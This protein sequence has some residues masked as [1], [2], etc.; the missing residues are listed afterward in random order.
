MNAGRIEEFK[1]VPV[2]GPRDL[3]VMSALIPLAVAVVVALTACSEGGSQPVS[4]TPVAPTQVPVAAL[5]TETPLVEP[6]VSAEPPARIDTPTPKVVVVESPV[7]PVPT[8]AV[9]PSP[10]VTAT[11]VETT[12]PTP[13]AVATVSVTVGGVGEASSPAP[14]ALPA[15]IAEPTPAPVPEIEPTPTPYPDR[16]LTADEVHA[17][18]VEA[19]AGVD[20]YE[21]FVRLSVDGVLDD[22]WSGVTVKGHMSLVGRYLAPGLIWLRTVQRTGLPHNVTA[23][24]EPGAMLPLESGGFPGVEAILGKDE[25]YVRYLGYEREGPIP[26]RSPEPVSVDP[27]TGW[28]RLAYADW[29][30][31]MP[32]VFTD[33]SGMLV[34]VLPKLAMGF[35][36]LGEAEALFGWE[37]EEIDLRRRGQVWTRFDDFYYA[38]EELYLPISERGTF[39]LQEPTGVGPIGVVSSLLIRRSDSRPVQLLANQSLTGAPGLVYVFFHYGG[40]GAE[41][42]EVPTEYQEFDREAHQELR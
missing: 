25:V 6:T 37:A 29:P 35:P 21:F 5:P 4:T 14:E 34:R 9:V 1:E 15:A 41:P 10:T 22:G 38:E 30:A 20:S 40:E 24:H 27:L 28:Y 13:V 23:G 33:P 39:N 31:E 32:D 19:L 26:D 16:E 11:E 17:L 8:P 2:F 3:K 7:D 42:I 36:S 12:P 18:G